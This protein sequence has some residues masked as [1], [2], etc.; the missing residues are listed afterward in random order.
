MLSANP[1]KKLYT[2]FFEWSEMSSSAIILIG[3]IG[4][5]KTTLADYLI[6]QFDKF[7][8]I[9][10]GDYPKKVLSSVS[11]LFDKPIEL[12]SFYDRSVK[13]IYRPLLIEF[14]TDI[15]RNQL[16]P[17]VWID[18]AIYDIKKNKFNFVVFEDV[19]FDNEFKKICEN[20]ENVIVIELKNESEVDHEKISVDGCQK[21]FKLN[22]YKTNSKIFDEVKSIIESHVVF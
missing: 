21:I 4:S 13:E 18:A 2:D 17:D 10:I 16:N 20:F 12:D 1:F 8:K 5:G 15:F 3:N 14:A 11:K 7:H 19:R 22:S 6:Q 9:A